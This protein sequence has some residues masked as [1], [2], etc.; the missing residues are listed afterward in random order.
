MQGEVPEAGTTYAQAFYDIGNSLGVSPFFLA[1]RVYQEQGSAGTSPLISGNYPGYEGYYNYYNIGATGTTTTD[2]YVN[3]L[4]TAQNKGW[5][6]RMKALTGGAQYISQNYILKGQDTLYL[7]KFDVDASYNGLYSHQYQQNITAPM[8]EGGKIRTAYSQTNALENPFVFKIPV[9]NNMPATACPSPDNQDNTATA[10]ALRAFVVRLYEDALGRTSYQDSEIDYW[11]QALRNGEKTGA[12]VAYGFFFS[13]EF[14]NKGL[15]DDIFVDVLYKVMFDRQADSGG[16]S[17]WLSRLS[18]GMSREYVYRGF[19]DSQEFANVCGQY[20]V[21][22][23]TISLGRY[24]DQNEG[25]TSF[26][27]RLY[28]KLLERQGDEDG[29]ENW[30]RVILTR[31]DTAENVA[32]GFVFSSE[33]TNRNTSNEEFVKIMYQ[34]FLNREYDQTGLEDWVGQLNAGVSRE[35][36]FR[37]FAG[38][39]EFHNLMVAYG[40]E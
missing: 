30:C 6:T 26:V 1:C 33:F 3:G 12:E 29:M 34:T 32:Y 4:K 11:Y 21:R 17:D 31:A 18:N 2:V 19:A 38:S 23:G 13:T 14:Q 28:V 7:Q 5:D 15:P 36:V 20:G 35:Q 40:V 22:Q 39:V 10:A 25:V 24:R 8:T 9:Y 37:G 16:K 27:N